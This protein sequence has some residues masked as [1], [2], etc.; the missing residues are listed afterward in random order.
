MM[1]K[2]EKKLFLLDA[3]AL[4]YRAHFAFSKNPRINTKGINTG[5]TLGFTNALVEIIHKEKPTHIVVAFDTSAPT[6]RHKAFRAYKEHREAQPEDITIAIPY[7]K[8][9]VKAFGIPVLE[10]DGYEAD[11]IIGTLAQQASQ[12][13]FEVYMMTTDKDF[14]QLVSDHIY[15]YKPAFMGNSVAILGKKEI[16]AKWEVENVAQ[17]RDIL[18]LWGDSVDNIPGIPKIGEKTAKKLIQRFGS[19]ENLVANA[20]QLT[21]SLKENVTS[22]GQQGI[23]SKELATIHTEVP[24]AFN[25]AQSRYEGPEEE[26][27]KSIFSE[28]EFRALTKRLW[29]TE[30]APT[31]K[32]ALPFQTTLFASTEA[33]D[34]SKSAT[35]KKEVTT[36]SLATLYTTKHQYHLIST[37]EQRKSLMNYLMLQDTFCF[38]TETTGLDPHQASLLGIAFAYY[39]GEAYYVTVPED[40]EKTKVIVQELRTLFEN[41]RSSKVGQNLKYD[42]IVLKRYGVTVHGTIFDTMLAHYLLA[43][44]SRHNMNLMAENYLHYSPLSIETLIGKRGSTQGNM[45]D[46]DLEK[47]KEYAGEDVDIT[48]QLKQKLAPLLAQQL[49]QLFYDVELP[50]VE[51]L[52]SMECAGVKIDLTTLKELSKAM[53]QES[54]TL[55]QEIYEL[56]GE[57]FNIASPKQLGTILFDKLKL[58][59][60]PPKTKTGQYATGEDVLTKLAREHEIVTKI[61]AHRELQKLKSTYV[62]ALPALISP[63]DGLIH[64]SYNQAVTAT[65]R[66][67]STHPNLQNI[68]IRTE[69]GR[70]I[71]K[72]FVPRDKDYVLL[73]ADYSQ[74]ELRIMAS[75]AKDKTMIA[76]FK[77]D[78][79]IHATTASKLFKVPLEAVDTDMRRKAKTANFGIIY[80]ISAFGLS[81][82]LNIPRKEASAI[83]DAYFEEFPAIKAYMGKVIHEAREKKYVT[84]LLGR[85]RFLRDINSRN[86]T[87]RGFAERNA[88]NSPIQG[89]AAEMIKVAMIRIHTWMKKEKLQSKMIMQVHDELVFD[90]YKTEVELLKEKV[91]TFMKEALPIKVPVKVAIGMGE[92]WLEVH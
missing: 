73:S 49:E 3:M 63:I 13:E 35:A 43:P 51:V 57:T 39:P 60:K 86:A 68:P 24:L 89:S 46:V 59:E 14:A 26:K 22:Y 66:L 52:A 17:I 19:V 84:T 54:N 15:L 32:E 4:I 50:L 80:G 78:K 87:V 2:C 85:K 74:I 67:S 34:S 91:P 69:K 33:P 31:R 44:D 65:G 48:L 70:A 27:I 81:Q 45:R 16:L 55:E 92:N 28:L 53:V 12:E 30:S 90:T 8:K 5:A 36:P 21:G 38:D 7:V 61:I 71:R 25:L 20:D 1:N 56:A 64:T 76:A 10:K 6:F 37:A 18:G 23:L 41:E 62:D 83:I 82:R 29:G 75:F 58:A 40:Y 77:A 88:I 42:I 47:V 9:I 72:A 79:D 11:D